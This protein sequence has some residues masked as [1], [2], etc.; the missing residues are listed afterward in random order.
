MADNHIWDEAYGVSYI[1]TSGATTIATVNVPIKVAGTTTAGE[2]EGFTHTT[3]G[4][5][6]YTG[7]ETAVF[8]ATIHAV[9][10]PA[11]HPA[12]LLI[13]IG[14][15]GVQDA[16]SLLGLNV[17]A[18]TVPTSFNTTCL[19]ELET[20]DYVEIFIE[21]NTDNGNVELDCGH[22]VLVRQ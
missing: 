11:A 22:L 12:A 3:P 7:I 1:S 14:V 9:I 4:K 6:T 19:V 21:N 17:A 18:H 10:D 20:D 2:L 16:A 5:L 13:G 8:K 15:N